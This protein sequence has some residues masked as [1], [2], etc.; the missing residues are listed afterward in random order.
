ME[1]KPNVLVVD[2]NPAVR[3]NLRKLFES[4][5]FHGCIEAENGR[6]AIRLAREHQPSLITLDLSMP[7]MT[8]LQVVPVIREFL[9]D[10][11]II[12]VTLYGEELKF[13]DLKALGVSAVFPKSAPLN[14]LL[15]MAHKLVGL[16]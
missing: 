1:Q 10:T 11:P 2:D 8:G 16:K 12:L 13:L 4:D 14:D 9:P 7:G 5:G 3:L 6:E 15:H